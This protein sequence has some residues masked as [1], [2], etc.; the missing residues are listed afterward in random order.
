MRTPNPD[1]I[2]DATSVILTLPQRK[3]EVETGKFL[4]A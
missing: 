4:E 1:T 3:W 2:T